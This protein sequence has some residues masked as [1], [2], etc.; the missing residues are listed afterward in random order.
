M[1]GSVVEHT[2][3]KKILYKIKYFDLI[4]PIICTRRSHFK[5][6]QA[7]WMDKTTRHY[8]QTHNSV[9]KNT[10]KKALCIEL[11]CN[12]LSGL[13]VNTRAPNEK[14]DFTT[15]TYGVDAYTSDSN[16]RQPCKRKIARPMRTLKSSQTS[17]LCRNTTVIHWT[18]RHNW[19]ITT[20]K[21]YKAR[22]LPQ[23]R[24]IILTK[25]WRKGTPC[26]IPEDVIC[27]N[28]KMFQGR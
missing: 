20:P 22:I 16:G 2:I 23:T 9:I 7:N 28:D 24:H 15:L 12:I 3:S 19:S 25:R 4:T 11:W 27:L 10:Q 14:D 1:G 26:Y 18:V 13:Q 21:R 8:G 5:I 17:L 6:I